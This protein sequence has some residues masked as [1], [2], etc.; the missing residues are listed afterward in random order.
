MKK[1]KQEAELFK[2]A[3]LAGVQYAQERKAATALY[4]ALDGARQKIQAGERNAAALLA[5]GLDGIANGLD[6]GEPNADNL[7][8]F[9]YE[10]LTGRLL[11]ERLRQ[12]WLL[13]LQQRGETSRASMVA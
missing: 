10:E 3:L 12:T 4:R 7:Y 2:A 9:S 6:A 1:L 13:S 11:V 8:T 5:S